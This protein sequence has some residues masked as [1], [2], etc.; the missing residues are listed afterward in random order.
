MVRAPSTQWPI[1]D[2]LGPFPVWTGQAVTACMLC[3]HVCFS[4]ICLHNEPTLGGDRLLLSE[5]GRKLSCYSSKRLVKG[6][7]NGSGC[8]E[9]CII[10]SFLNFLGSDNCLGW[11]AW[12]AWNPRCWSVWRA[13]PPRP[14][15]GGSCSTAAWW[16]TS[17]TTLRPSCSTSSGGCVG[18]ASRSSSFVGLGQVGYEIQYAPWRMMCLSQ[19]PKLVA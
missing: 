18:W 3:M 7:G 11:V 15:C 13:L 1:P 10:F 5:G 9:C 8:L 6:K 2:H 19:V 12:V 16:C 4:N 14:P 17:L